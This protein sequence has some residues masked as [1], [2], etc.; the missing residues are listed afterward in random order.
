MNLL[1]ATVAQDG[2]LTLAWGAS[3]AGPAGTSGMAGQTV[4]LGMRPDRL[5]L[6]PQAQAQAS[7]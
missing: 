4:T 5:A 3:V 7:G 1:P 2:H 6:V